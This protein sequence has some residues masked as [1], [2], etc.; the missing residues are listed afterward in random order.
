MYYCQCMN[1][2]FTVFMTTDSSTRCSSGDSCWKRTYRDCWETTCSWCCHQLPEQGTHFVQLCRGGNICVHTEQQ[3]HIWVQS[4]TLFHK[5]NDPVNSSSHMHLTS[6]L[7]HTWPTIIFHTFALNNY[8]QS[9]GQLFGR[10]TPQ[11]DTPCV[12]VGV[13]E[14]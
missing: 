9:H 6:V 11:P 14:H 13:R 3:K 1:S 8:T 7:Y 12:T 5:F 10:A 2:T 4:N